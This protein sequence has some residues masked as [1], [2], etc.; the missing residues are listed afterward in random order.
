MASLV[1]FEPTI[2]RLRSEHPWPLDDR[3]KDGAPD[4]NRTRLNPVD[5]RA[6]HQ[7]DS[8]ANSMWV[9]VNQSHRPLHGP[10]LRFRSP[11]EM[12]GPPGFEPGSHPSEGCALSS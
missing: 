4:G 5:S 12:V 2:S 6:P 3:N 1:G 11:T 10:A 9:F 8:R 7:S